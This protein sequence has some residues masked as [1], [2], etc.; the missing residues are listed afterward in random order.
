MKILMTT[1][2][3]GGVW[4]YALEL[5]GGLAQHDVVVHLATMGAPISSEQRNE[6]ESVK[7][8]VLHESDYKLEWMSDCWDD[9]EAAGEWLLELQ[10]AIL[11]DVVH[12]NGYAHGG[13]DWRA[14]VLM[15]G[16]SCVFS[17]WEAVR[18]G[19]P[20]DEW[21]KYRQEVL[22]GLHSADHIIAPTYAMLEQLNKHYGPLSNTSVIANGR[23]ADLFRPLPKK[24]IIFSAGRLWDEA[25]NLALLDEAAPSLSW[26]VIVAGL[27]K[28]PD[29]GDVKCSNVRCL[30]TLPAREV[31]LWLG[32]AAIYTLPARYEPFGLSILEA[33]LSGCALVLGD[34]PSLREVWGEA[35]LY[36]DPGNVTSLASAIESL[37]KDD[38]LR[39]R[40][41][42]RAMNRARYYSV[43]RM[44]Q[45]YLASYLY[46]MRHGRHGER[47]LRSALLQGD[48]PQAPQAIIDF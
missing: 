42:D 15:V 25:K 16:H 22:R 45:H 21:V 32:E 20:P 5:A 27:N 17:W 47:R 12:L 44:A 3:V 8:L 14:P 11:P 26:P 33:A 35:A 37:I 10:A 43:Q 29:G 13:L 48:Y 2:T 36:V 4:T 31:A 7:G 6:A 23:S 40:M 1:D 18:G 34:I 39:A 28:H 19:A 46:L 38:A 9:V 30:G 24:H 41:A